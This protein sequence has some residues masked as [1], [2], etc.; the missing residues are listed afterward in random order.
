M[1][2]IEKTKDVIYALRNKYDDNGW[3]YAFLQQVSNGTGTKCNRWCDALAVQLW[4]SRGLEIIGFE[5]KVSRADWIKELKHPEKADAIAQY[6]HQWYLVVGNAD[7]VQL[8]ELPTTWGLMVPHTKKTLK[9]VKPAVRNEKP[10]PVDMPFLCA[11]LRRAVEQHTTK[12]KLQS[13]FNRGYDE[14]YD[15]G[16][17]DIE[18]K[19]KWRDERNT[20][21]ENQIDEFEKASGFRLTEGWNKPKKVGEAVKMVL[22]GSY[23]REKQRLERLHNNALSIAEDI[24]EELDKIED[25]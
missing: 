19:I 8:G 7:I 12:A 10:K 9:I 4:E 2:K 13:E 22:N 17:K 20:K 15:D 23:I 6:C 21:L 25:N 5:V 24:K 18:D 14:G 11:V 1:V 3:S 16:K